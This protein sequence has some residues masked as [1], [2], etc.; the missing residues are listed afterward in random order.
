M[1]SLQLILLLMQIFYIISSSKDEDIYL[2][3]G[4]KFSLRITASF[5]ST[6][7][8]ECNLPSKIQMDFYSIT[9][10]VGVCCIADIFT[11]RFAG[12]IPHEY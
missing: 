3:I 4:G 7:S 11:E 10:L 1:Y 8:S 6:W 2:Y 9:S 5:H 12:E